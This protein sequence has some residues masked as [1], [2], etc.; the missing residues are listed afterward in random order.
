MDITVPKT[1]THFNV[2]SNHDKT[3]RILLN[4]LLAVQLQNVPQRA[5]AGQ[6]LS[7]SHTFLWAQRQICS[8]PSA[9]LSSNSA[10]TSSAFP[11]D[12]LGNTQ[13]FFSRV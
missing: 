3:A 7:A 1:V 9:P 13:H 10:H 4:F 6:A 11:R 12:T 8:H 2:W 5:L